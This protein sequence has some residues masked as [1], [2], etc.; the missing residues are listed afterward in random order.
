MLAFY[1]RWQLHYCFKKFLY[2]LNRVYSNC[3]QWEWAENVD[4]LNCQL[5]FLVSSWG[6]MMTS[7]LW[8]MASLR[9]PTGRE[10]WYIPASSWV[11]GDSVRTLPESSSWTVVFRTKLML[12]M[13]SPSAIRLFLRSSFLHIMLGRN[14][15]EMVRSGRRPG[16]FVKIRIGELF[17][18]INTWMRWEVFP[19]S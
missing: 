8:T 9:L 18:W 11:T 14:S 17:P 1:G 19:C 16:W 3:E 15:S 4:C 10:H 7:T 12:R 13:L 2:D 5:M 6:E